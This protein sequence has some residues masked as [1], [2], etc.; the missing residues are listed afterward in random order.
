MGD[1][2]WCRQ[3]RNG[4]PKPSWLVNCVPFKRIPGPGIPIAAAPP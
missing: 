1:A 3:Y 4:Q 2:N